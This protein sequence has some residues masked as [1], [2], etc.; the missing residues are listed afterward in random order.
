MLSAPWP[1]GTRVAIALDVFGA[2]GMTYV[3]I[4]SKRAHRQISY[5]MMAEDW[6]WHVVIP[7]F[8]YATLFAAGLVMPS[9]PADALFVAAVSPAILL[10]TGIR[11]AWDTVTYVVVSRNQ[12]KNEAQADDP[13][14]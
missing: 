14:A 7:F 1:A 5:Q 10:Y 2:A 8:A 12:K 11:N 4:V 9:R 3:L 13:S 6:R